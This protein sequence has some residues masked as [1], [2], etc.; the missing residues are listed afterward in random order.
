MG[1]QPALHRVLPAAGTVKAEA[2]LPYDDVRALL[3]EEKTFTVNEC[4]CRLQQEQ[5]RRDVHLPDEGLPHLL[6]ARTG[7]PRAI[8][9][10]PRRLRCWT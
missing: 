9:P 8:S 4:I 7:P 2:I 5:R 6:L 3:L 1:P 10:R